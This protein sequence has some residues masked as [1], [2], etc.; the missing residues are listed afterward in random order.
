MEKRRNKML[1]NLKNSTFIEFHSIS[2]EY[3]DVKALNRISFSINKGEIFGYIGPNGAGKT[4]TIKI[5]VGLI[6]NYEGEIVIK[7]DG[8]INSHK[9]IYKILGYLPQDAEFQEWRTVNHALNTF[10]LLS[11]I[12][13]DQLNLRII[14]VLKTVGL[15]DVRNK[16]ITH[17]SGGMQQK[18]R[19]AQALL[20]N[21]K[22]LVLDEPMSGL[23]P[24]SRYQMKSIIK[25]LVKKDITIFLSSHILSDVQDIA[26]RI[27][28]IN[29]GKILKIG[30]PEELECDF[31]VGNDIEIVVE[32]GT[33]GIKDLD[34]ILGVELV[35]VD[36]TQTNRQIIHLNADANIDECIHQIMTK[37]QE[38][39]IHVRNFNLLKPSL[40]Q[41][42]LKY[43]GG[44][45][46]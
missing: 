27:G 1:E 21:P 9:D 46:E 36:S 29:A 32:N 19:M 7:G 16:K 22:L 3:K 23:D 6:Q 26:T 11:G 17:L 4:T 40:E 13:K 12:P 35:I 44:Q 8:I 45:I 20:H 30:T 39:Q 24:T 41:V 42:Y 38:Q 18:L 15:L 34:E 43:V 25:E 37:I 10:G 31:Q 33:P 5:L 14:D 2:K 28:I